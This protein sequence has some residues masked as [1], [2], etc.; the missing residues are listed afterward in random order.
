MNCEE[1]ERLMVDALGG[2]LREADRPTFEA[3]LS[4]CDRCRRDY[5]SSQSAVE[6]MQSLPGPELVTVRR[7]GAR[8][9]IEERASRLPAV[10]SSQRG[11]FWR[12]AGSGVLRYAAGLLIA[13]TAGYALHT[14]QTMFDPAQDLGRGRETM[15]TSYLGLDNLQGAL[16]RAHVGRPSR[17]GLAK[18]LIATASRRR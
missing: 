7:E 4:R 13:F 10:D 17:S 18:A 8:L 5:D 3:H 11:W 1:F 6:T 12:R 16:V 15:L 14:A 9:V 2:E